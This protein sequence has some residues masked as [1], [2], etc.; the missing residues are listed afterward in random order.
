MTEG[1][2]GSPGTERCGRTGNSESGCFSG[3]Q[4]VLGAPARR[5]SCKIPDW[6]MTPQPAALVVRSR[7]IGV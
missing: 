1:G 2:G 3:R 4:P 5:F 7:Y 6:A